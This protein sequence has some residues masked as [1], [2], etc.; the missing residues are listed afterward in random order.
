MTPWGFLVYRLA[1]SPSSTD[2]RWAQA[3]QK[4]IA[5]AITESRD[6]IEENDGNPDTATFIFEEGPDLKGLS[7]DD[8]RR[9]FNPTYPTDDAPPDR[10]DGMCP[11]VF[12]VVD[13]ASLES[14]LSSDENENETPYVV[15]VDATT[16][17]SEQMTMVG[18]D[19]RPVEWDG[20]MKVEVGAV[21]VN[22]YLRAVGEGAISMGEIHPDVGEIW[23]G[24]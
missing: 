18:D 10:Q 3:K 24:I 23:E 15:A 14:I 21:M 12:L 1:W 19:L 16:T 11:M 4:L 2:A 17:E 5:G 20:T 9:K 6:G 7:I 22:L 8:V 13:D